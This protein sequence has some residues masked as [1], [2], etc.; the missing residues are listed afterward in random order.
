MHSTR[1]NLEP[2]SKYSIADQN[3]AYDELKN[4][5]YQLIIHYDACYSSHHCHQIM[6][7][8]TFK[9]SH[10]YLD[11]D[12]T[13]YQT[14]DLYW[15]TNTAPADDRNGNER[16][17]HVEM[18]NLSWEA[19]KSESD[20]HKVSSDQYRLK[21]GRWELSLS[22]QWKKNLRNPNFRTYADTGNAVTS[23]DES[24]VKWFACGIS[25]MS[26]IEHLSAFALVSTNYCLKF[27]CRS[28]TT[29]KRAVCLLIEFATT[30]P[31]R[32]FLVMPT[33]KKEKSMV[34]S[35]NMTQAR[36]STGL[37][38]VEPWIVKSLTQHFKLMLLFAK[39]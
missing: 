6:T 12:G 35:A 33:F 27:V 7:E 8:S 30:Q 39:F 13:L 34:S 26:S 32:E 11:L 20:W 22:D 29:K 10:F 15:K 1:S 31:L 9:G 3:K 25:L 4:S 24:T 36:H 19:L 21:K 38:Y 37:V 18:S 17:V 28:H 16:A 14:C 23:V 5:V 2:P